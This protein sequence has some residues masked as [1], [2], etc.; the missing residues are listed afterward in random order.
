LFSASIT[1]TGDIF[2]STN[3]SVP[4]ELLYITFAVLCRH[5]SL[6]FPRI[7]STEVP[8]QSRN[9]VFFLLL[10]SFCFSYFEENGEEAAEVDQ[11][12][13]MSHLNYESSVLR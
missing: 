8:T 4:K 6:E 9:T 7:A 1:S 13:S 5:R 10:R 2:C 12:R 3:E 11:N